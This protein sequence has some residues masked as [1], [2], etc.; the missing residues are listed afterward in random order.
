MTLRKFGG[1]KGFT[2]VELL[3]VIVL[4]GIIMALVTLSGA[5][6][7]QS[8]NAQTEA[9]RL[10]RSV[11]SLRS[12][13]LSCYADTQVSLGITPGFVSQ[14][15]IEREIATYSDRSLLDET[16]RYGDIAVSGDN[17]PVYIGFT[18]PWT[19]NSS[20]VGEMAE[21]VGNRAA[22]YDITFDPGTQRTM[23]RIR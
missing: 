8:T 5:N 23:I 6:M 17:G 12:A 13:W 10:I 11:H 18:G 19:L 2:L 21:V 20:T 7:I 1:K 4:M 22:D 14:P 3:L 16:E 15:D 9:R